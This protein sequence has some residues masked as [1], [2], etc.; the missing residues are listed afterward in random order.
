MDLSSLKALILVGGHGTRLRPVVSDRPKALAPVGGRPFLEHLILWSR[1]QGITN[2]VLCVGYW[3]REIMDY[4]GDGSRWGVCIAYSV[5]PSPL[6][7]GGAL[8]LAGSHVSDTFLALNGDTYFFD[9]VP[10]LLEK[11]RQTQVLLTLGLS[12]TGPRTASGQIALDPRGRVICFEEKV[13]PVEGG[14]LSAGLYVIEPP[15]LETIPSGRRVSLEREVF[16]A[17]VASGA[18]VYGCPLPHG[19]LDM[20]IPEGYARLERWLA[21]L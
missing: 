13:A 3:A 19:H 7:T 4:G 18:P 6:G 20:G 10:P 14:W 12:A 16:P 5:E 17:L 15:L 21:A 8:R 2:L 1:D 9:P 11:H